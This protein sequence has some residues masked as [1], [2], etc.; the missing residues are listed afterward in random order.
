[1][2]TQWLFGEVTTCSS[3]VPV[4]KG[5]ESDRSPGPQLEGLGWSIVPGTHLRKTRPREASSS[6]EDTYRRIGPDRNTIRRKSNPLRP[7]DYSGIVGIIEG[8]W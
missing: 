8:Q 3:T 4:A 1:M 2:I 6:P 7:W 5:A